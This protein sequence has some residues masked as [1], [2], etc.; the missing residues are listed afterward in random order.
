MDTTQPALCWR[1]SIKTLD[2]KFPVRECIECLD[3]G[4]V[5]DGPD[6]VHGCPVPT[7]KAGMEFSQTER[8]CD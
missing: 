8:Y 7:C 1:D 4:F 3:K 2:E 5:I 6:G